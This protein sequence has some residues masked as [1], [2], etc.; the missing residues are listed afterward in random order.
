LFHSHFL[1][2]PL[3]SMIDSTRKNVHVLIL[4]EVMDKQE[5]PSF[6]PSF[7]SRQFAG[8]ATEGTFDGSVLISDI[9]GFTSLTESLFTL[10]KKGAEQLSEILNSMF[11]KMI[12]SVYSYGGFVAN[13]AGDAFTAVFPGDDGE[14]ACKAARMIRASVPETVTA[15][16]GSYRTGIRSGISSG[17]IRW[18]IYGSGPFA[19]LINGKTVIEAAALEASAETGE[20]ITG[21]EVSNSSVDL[22]TPVS[23]EILDSDSMNG[24]MTADRNMER[25]FVHPDYITRMYSPEFRDVASVFTGFHDIGNMNDLVDTFL[26]TAEEYGGYFNLLDCG[27]KGN[28]VL[29]LFG[30]PVTSEKNIARSVNFAVA[31]RDR[32]GDRVR[33]GIT[34]GR[35]FAGFIG[36]PSLRG[37]YTVIGDKVNTAARLMQSCEDGDIRVS[38][39]IG[40]EFKEKFHCN[41]FH[42]ISLKGSSIPMNFYSLERRR[43]VSRTLSFDNTFV[44]RNLE[45]DEVRLLADR[46]LAGKR[47]GALIISGEAGIGKTRFAYHAQSCLDGIKLIYLKCDEILSKSLNPIESLFDDVFG[48]SGSESPEESEAV[49]ERNFSELIGEATESSITDYHAGNLKRLKYVLKGFMGIDEGGEYAL[50]DA[51][52]RFD[53]TILAF[54]HLI[55]LLAEGKRL[56][57]VLDDFQWADQ[58]T[59]SIMNDLFSQLDFENP[60][61]CILTRPSPLRE[62]SCLLPETAEVLNIDL[63]ALPEKEQ[64]DILQGILPCAPTSGLCEIVENKAEGNPFYIEQITMYLLDNELIDFSNG[65]AELA[66]P[67]VQLPGSI[68]DIIISRI[69]RL[70][71]D[72]RQT[73]KNASVLGRTFNVRVLSR[74]LK[75]THM[76][77]HLEMGS[78]ARIWSRLSEIQYIFRHALIRD[79]VY[80]MQMDKQLRKLHLLAGEIIE[81]LYPDDERM[82]A[83]LSYHFDKSTQIDRMLL[84]TLKA[85]EYAYNN[86]RNLESIE[87]YEK[88]IQR[89][90]NIRERKLAVFKLGVV[91]ELTGDWSRALDLYDE[92]FAYARESGE[93]SLLFDSMSRKGFLLHR[94]GENQKALECF[95]QAENENI[96]ICN[97]TGLASIYN[98]IGTVYIDLN[99]PGEAKSYFGRALSTVENLNDGEDRSEL[100]MFTYNNLGL[101]HQKMNDLEK[102]SQFYGKSMA[103]AKKLDSRRNLAALNFG[104]ICYLR[105]DIDGAEKHYR[106]AM[107]DAEKTGDRH[108]VR[109]MLNNLAAISTARGDYTGALAIFREALVLARSMNDRKG[110]RLLSQ[111]IGEILFYLGEYD[112]SETAFSEAIKTALDLDDKRGLGNA[113]GKRGIMLFYRGDIDRAAESLKE[114]VRYS[115]EAENMSTAHECMYF[116]AR[117]LAERA[118]EREVLELLEEMRK[119]PENRI[120]QAS[121][122]YTTAI[123]AFTEKSCGNFAKVLTLTDDIIAM[124][125]ESE[126]EALARSI[127]FDI[128]GAE[129][130]RNRAVNIYRDLYRK[131]PMAHYNDLIDSLESPLPE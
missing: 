53:N 41:Y 121:G 74:M 17:E 126:G 84:Y 96:R 45:L 32:F 11:S 61:L 30:A 35:V 15:A 70:E 49:F 98:N 102:A 59:L 31:L 12:D 110:I 83:D 1:A 119:I 112:A 118:C 86:F 120:S 81:K 50:L 87:M 117:I 97:S 89:Q 106:I 93:D 124:F 22:D 88:Y 113:S 9:S 111:N 60:I 82:Y 58:D 69:D 57:L 107:N 56:F 51:K 8:K 99:D 23:G 71:A 125:P 20:I 6:I 28:L 5:G 104:N 80:E 79:A 38:E 37:H 42:C 13:F 33:S 72:I 36:S 78:E 55:R 101:V 90:E 16:S 73:V 48:T 128:T 14:K 29:T 68:L 115:V 95:S 127:I 46:T 54:M 21:A 77:K 25:K 75:G 64:Q 116:L 67:G 34:Y 18:N 103:L 66:S 10:R 122:W 109:V 91:Y 39:E 62:I 65:R 40:K 100:V 129:E 108:L 19:Y 4:K 24:C 43:S 63:T 2:E 52:S 123:E 26:R 92:A 130:E 76:S 47:T 94:M 7:V 114:G 44:G 27:D 131:S 85:A 105:E 3:R